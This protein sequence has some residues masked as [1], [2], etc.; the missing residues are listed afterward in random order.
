MSPSLIYRCNQLCAIRYQ[1]MK[2]NAKL[3]NVSTLC[4]W[5][6]GDLKYCKKVAKYYIYELLSEQNSTYFQL[7][8]SGDAN[9]FS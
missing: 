2:T 9:A 7:G 3:L 8:I 1:S 5:T 6:G 4:L